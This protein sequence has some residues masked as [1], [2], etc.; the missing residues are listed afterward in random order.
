[1]L[2]V[3]SWLAVRCWVCCS[4]FTGARWS[5]VLGTLG[6]RAMVWDSMLGN[7]LLTLT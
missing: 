2:D 1:M 6:T 3:R 4:G 7:F 5:V